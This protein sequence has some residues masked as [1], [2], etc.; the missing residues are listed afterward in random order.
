MIKHI[1][2]F[3]FREDATN[4]QIGKAYKGLLGLKDRIYGI[5]TITVGK[6]VSPEKNK[7]H[8][9]SHVLEIKFKDESCRDIYL[10]HPEH[11]W[12]VENCINPVKED[13]IV[14]DYEVY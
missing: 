4:E 7:T 9:Y 5:E 10:W 12:V 6:N 13:V 11:R 3:K 8:E 2:L 14:A 1:V